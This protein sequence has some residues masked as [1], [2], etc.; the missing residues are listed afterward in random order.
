MGYFRP[1][2]PK[3][4][5]GHITRTLTHGFTSALLRRTLLS[6]A[7]GDA[8]FT[9]DT[10]TEYTFPRRC[11]YYNNLTIGSLA[12]LKPPY[13]YTQIIGVRGTLTLD[14]AIDVSE[15]VTAQGAGGHGGGGVIIVANEIVG[16]GTIRANG[17]NGRT[18]SDG[19]TGAREG[20]GG[21]GCWGN[22]GNAEGA[23]ESGGRGGVNPKSPVF[24]LGDILEHVLFYCDGYGAAGGDTKNKYRN[25][26]GS[27]AGISIQGGES[28]YSSGSDKIGGGGGG[29]GFI[30]IVSLSGV[31]GL[32]L[33]A[34]GGAGA[35]DGGG[36]GGGGLII[37]IAPS[38]SSTKDVSGG[39]GTTHGA[40]GEDG[41]TLFIPADP[42]EVI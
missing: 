1:L 27:L 17:G 41:L 6:G 42:R 15:R 30:L 26:S 3:K 40:A 37:I 23:G 33:E 32:T 38:D 19:Y 14:G 34:K 5:W 4:V 16:T 22:G 31:P 11:M 18:A 24:L 9:P 12:T 29:G 25:T 21:A 36:G 35:G 39:A 7:D 20:G 10:A 28:P 8:S 2:D 13:G